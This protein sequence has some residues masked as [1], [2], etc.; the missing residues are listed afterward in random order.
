MRCFDWGIIEGLWGKQKKNVELE[1]FLYESIE[2]L[3]NII[4]NEKSTDFEIGLDY[5]YSPDILK[6]IVNGSI[7]KK[8]N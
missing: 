6:S 7:I 8:E 3:N 4:L 2:Q 5:L 1:K